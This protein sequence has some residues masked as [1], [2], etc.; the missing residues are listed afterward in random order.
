MAIDVAVS[1][2]Y[3]G[4]AIVNDPE[5]VRRCGFDPLA[6]VDVDLSIAIDL[7]RFH[8]RSRRRHSNVEEEGEVRRTHSIFSAAA[9]VSTSASVLSRRC[10]GEFDDQTSTS[11]TSSVFFALSSLKDRQIERIG[12]EGEGKRRRRRRKS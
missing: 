4:R 12:D 2:T 10:F 8:C 5:I 3:D 7:V 11:K 9:G 1:S 6:N